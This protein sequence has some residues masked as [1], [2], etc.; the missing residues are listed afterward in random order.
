VNS[1]ER[2]EY[3]DRPR[4]V[5]TLRPWPIGPRPDGRR[6]FG[7]VSGAIVQALMEAESDLCVQQI[8][9]LVACLLGSSVSRHSIKSYMH[10]RSSGS[11]PVFE[12][13]SRGVTGCG[14]SDKRTAAMRL[15]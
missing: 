13:V 7:S 15:I 11:R 6:K 5:L 9:V 1:S 4:A 3:G 10:E 2:G 14:M 12:R 8:R